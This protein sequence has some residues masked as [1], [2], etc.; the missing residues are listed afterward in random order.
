MRI[1]SHV[2]LWQRSQYHEV[3]EAYGRPAELR[4]LL[5]DFTAADL[6]ECLDAAGVDRA[7]L[8]QMAQTD[9]HNDELLSIATSEAC[10]GAVIGW[11]DL[12]S[13][14]L[15]QRLETLATNPLFRGIRDPLEGKPIDWLAQPPI[16]RG[17]RELARNGFLFELLIGKEH[18]SSV[19]SLAREIPE[20]PLVI[21]HF[22]KPTKATLEDWDQ[23]L[24][25]P[26]ASLPQVYV[27]LSG[28]M[29]LFPPS[30]WLDWS[31][32]EIQ[33]FLDRLLNRLGPMRLLTGT[34]WPV[35]TLAGSYLRHT[36]ALEAILSSL[37]VVVRNL[38][39]GE[40]AHRLY[41]I[42]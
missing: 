22:G 24:L 13:D 28:I 7:V 20:L 18:W 34:D 11:V 30:H 37:S 17:L 40:N 10:I 31:V 35:A 15:A 5:R 27:K 9:S 16:R 12:A 38:I 26:I 2:H 23:H 8:I 25:L 39:Q 36:E 4:P 3:Y 29:A 21:N 32:P 42:R 1:D 6:R 14:T 41:A 33:P 19:V